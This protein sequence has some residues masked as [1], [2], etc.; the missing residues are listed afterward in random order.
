MEELR[1]KI[2]YQSANGSLGLSQAVAQKIVN[3]LSRQVLYIASALETALDAK[4][5]SSAAKSDLAGRMRR[6]IDRAQA[7]RIRSF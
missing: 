3:R 5:F 4:D 2:E 7:C 1:T 6:A